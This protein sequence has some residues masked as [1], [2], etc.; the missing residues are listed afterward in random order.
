MSAA[1]ETADLD[2][3]AFELSLANTANPPVI[4]R[5]PFP[6]SVY[7]TQNRQPIVGFN[8]SCHNTKN[9]VA[10]SETNNRGAG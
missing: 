5:I 10:C 4:E 9:S 7:C 6:E 8:I 3:L 1:G 2:L